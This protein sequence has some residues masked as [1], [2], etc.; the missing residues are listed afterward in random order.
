MAFAMQIRQVRL[1]L[2]DSREEGGF[3]VTPRA[4]G[5][6]GAMDDAIRFLREMRQMRS[7]AGLGSAELAARVHYPRDVILAAEAGPSLPDLPVLSAYVRGC[8]GTVAEWEERWRCLTGSSVVSPGLPARPVG[9]SSLAA[10][11]ARA[12][13][14]A[15]AARGT[16]QRRI[17]AAISRAPAAPAAVSAIPSQA[18]AALPAAVAS[19]TRAEAM[20]LPATRAEVMP[21]PATRA[22]ITLPPTPASASAPVAPTMPHPP[23][24]AVMRARQVP[25]AS[26][27]PIPIPIPPA[28]LPAAT[29]VRRGAGAAASAVTQPSRTVAVRWPSASPAGQGPSISHVTIAAIVAGV[30]FVTGAI[31][32]L[33]LHRG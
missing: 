24:M 22:E 13:S 3:W 32:L 20:P 29:S 7:G 16:D 23:S 10:A 12:A 26:P 18:R 27:A 6:N 31:I 1:V 8:G 4:T 33:L 30:M 15:S 25:V 17:M 28:S 5:A 11:G 2:M 19:A 9:G 14:S 21:L